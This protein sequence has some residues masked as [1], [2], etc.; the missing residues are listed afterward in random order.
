MQPSRLKF[1]KF[2]PLRCVEA[3]NYVLVS[4]QQKY[5]MEVP[6]RKALAHCFGDVHTDLGARG[7]VVG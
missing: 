5:D 2:K 7:S 6:H 4:L 1:V 3:P